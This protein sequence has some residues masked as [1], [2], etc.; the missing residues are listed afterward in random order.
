MDLGLGFAS[1]YGDESVRI[2][3]CVC[4]KFQSR[5]QRKDKH[6][7]RIANNKKENYKSLALKAKQVLSDDD[8]SS[9]NSNDGLYAMTVRYFKKFF[10]RRG[11]FIR[12]PYDDKKNFRK[13]K[14]EIRE[15]RRCIKC[16]DPNHFISDQRAFVVGSWSDSGDDSKKEE[17]CL[18]AH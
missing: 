18:M 5:E 3:V 6:E 15:D 10:R 11:K 1:V 14:E 7:E 2:C 12:Q 16:G 9:S 13:I 4:V 17:I 8:T